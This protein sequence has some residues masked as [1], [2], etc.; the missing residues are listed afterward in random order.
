MSGEHPH[1]LGMSGEHPHHYG[2]HPIVDG[3]SSLQLSKVLTQLV[4]E[5]GTPYLGP[6]LLPSLHCDFPTPPLWA[7][8][9]SCIGTHPILLFVY[10]PF[11]SPSRL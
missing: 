1:L 8:F 5:V 10:T 9:P 4:L 7:L 6:V 11:L 3:M 2:E